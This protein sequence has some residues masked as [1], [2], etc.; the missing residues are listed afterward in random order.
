MTISESIGAA[1]GRR[2]ERKL[3]KKVGTSLEPGEEPL[4]GFIAQAPGEISRNVNAIVAVGGANLFNAGVRLGA[5]SAL[6]PGAE[7]PSP[8]AT[9]LAPAWS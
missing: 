9:P 6:V 7:V 2:L 3:F 1:S 8:A 5:L 4:V